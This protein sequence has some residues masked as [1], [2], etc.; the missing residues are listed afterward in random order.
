MEF[1][2]CAGVV[3]ETYLGEDGAEII[4]YKI[5]KKHYDK[6][7]IKELGINIEDLYLPEDKIHRGRR[8]GAYNQDRLFPG[9]R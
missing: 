7:Q 6:Q 5:G 3:E 9:I 8:L 1:K 2:P 4:K